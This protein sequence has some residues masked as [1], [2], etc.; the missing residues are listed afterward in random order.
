ML[1]CSAFLSFSGMTDCL[2]LVSALSCYSPSADQGIT[3]QGLPENYDPILPDYVLTF[4][5][6]GPGAILVGSSE[7]VAKMAGGITH[8]L[9]AE[10]KINVTVKLYCNYWDHVQ[11]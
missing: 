10:V 9:L 4:S 6:D 1:P 3:V 11:C 2:C 5:C 7:N 8:S